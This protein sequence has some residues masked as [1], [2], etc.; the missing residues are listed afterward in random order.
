MTPVEK[1]FKSNGWRPQDFQIDCWEHYNKGENLM[2]HAPTGTGKTYAIWGGILNEYFELKEIKEGINIIWITPLRALAVEIQKSTQQLSSDLKTGIKVDLRTGDTP[3]SRRIK[4]NQNFPF[5]LI[6]TPESLHVL[7]SSKK[8]KDFFKN[9]R[10]VVVDEWHELLGTKRGVQTELAISYLR[11]LIPKLKTIGISA[12]LGNKELAGE[13]LMGLGNNF[14][15]ITSKI[16][17][18]INVKS[19]IP[20]SMER[21]PWRGHLGTHLIGEVIKIIRKGKTTLIFTN[22]RS[23]CEIWY[24]TI[25]HSYPELA[26]EIA[27]HHGSIDKK[28]R[29]WVENSLRENKLKVVVCTSSLDLGVDFSPVEVCIQVG[30]PKGVGRFIQR[31][32]RSGHQPNNPSTIY[33]L[34]T[35]AIELIE[36]VALQEGIKKQ[37]IEDRLPHINSYDVLIQFL[38][39]LAIGEGFFPDEIFSLIKKTFSFQTIN[40]SKWKWILNFLTK[41]SQSL[42]YYDE[43]KKVQ[44]LEDGLMVV[45]D[46]GIALRHRLSM[47]TIVSDSVLKVKYQTGKQ[48]GTIE[49]WFVSKLSKGEVFTFAGKN[50]ELL[51]LKG[52]EVIVRKSKLNKA[53][54]PAW[55]GG[56]FSFSS[57][58]SD[59]LKNTF[60]NKK[61]YSTKEFKALDSMFYQQN[62]E[63]KIPKSDELLIERF[64]T[65]EGFHTLFYLFEGYAVNEAVSSLLAYRISLLYPITFTI[66]VNDYG[67]ELLSD[68]EFDRDIFI[69]NNLLTK[70]YLL[71]DLSKSV[72]I[73]EM[74]RRKFREIAVISGLVFQG[75]PTKPVKTKQLQ[76]GS[77]LFYDVFKEYEPDNLLYQQAIN[78]TF[79]HGI[80]SSRIQRTFEKIEKLKMV[81]KDCKYPTPFSFP[82]I[83]D[84][85]RS[86]MSSESVED[87]IRKM[88]LQLEKSVK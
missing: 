87:R 80:E 44:I 76:S 12:T 85:I 18:R 38:T 65:K 27:M 14:K 7:L 25:I 31:A 34:P 20:K 60:H 46:K 29:L 35:H 69:E 71:D 82:L 10:A 8:H 72:N 32:G 15:T 54:I 23:Q 79:D 52:M 21:F 47:G 49:E 59:L 68:Q 58:L 57:N 62:R 41:G 88:Y 22:T 30:S 2:L 24:H 13:I 77:Q 51:T 40:S 42:E 5:G 86:K 55:I 83:T 4:Q 11:F 73:S 43:F 48:L 70:D 17:K 74:S 66:S 75:Y 78:E 56:R 67:F 63:S 28:I 36:S 16:K 61:N 9:L 81:W 26:G 64:K 50:L 39:T 19:I 1:W 37:M 6:T 45:L 84:R 33:F 53:K 3:Q